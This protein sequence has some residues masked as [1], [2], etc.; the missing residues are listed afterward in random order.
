MRRHSAPNTV[1]LTTTQ[2]KALDLRRNIA[3]TASAGS[4][5]TR[6]LVERYLRILDERSDLGVENI[7]AITF[8]NKAAA[9]MRER[10]RRAVQE[11][12]DERPDEQERWVAVRDSLPAA[13]ISTIHAFCSS[14]LRQHPI[15]AGVDP[16]F[17]MLEDADRGVLIED[18]ADSALLRLSQLDEHDPKRAALWAGLRMWGRHRLSSLLRNL[19]SRR[20]AVAP[21]FE[22]IRGKAQDEIVAWMEEMIEEHRRASIA[23]LK[24]DENL[25]AFVEQLRASGPGGERDADASIKLND[26]RIDV[27]ASWDA[28]CRAG[29]PSSQLAALEEI[30]GINVRGGS[31]KVWPEAALDACKEALKAIRDGAKSGLKGLPELG[32][33]DRE[34]AGLLAALCVLVD[35]A[36]AEYW[37]H[38]GAGARL[39][40][41]DLEEIACRMLAEN[42]GGARD[43]YRGQFAYVLVDEFQDTNYQQWAIVSEIVGDAPDRLFVVGDPKQSIY[44]FRGAVIDVF[45]RVKRDAVVTRNTAAGLADAPFFDPHGKELPAEEHEKLGDV[46]MAESF[47]S[48]QAIADFVNHLFERVMAGGE[49]DWDPPYEPLIARREERAPGAVELLIAEPSGEAADGDDEY[50]ATPDD[51]ARLLAHRLCALVS[52][53][54]FNVCDPDTEELRPAKFDDVV[55]LLRGRSRLEY[56][57][58]AL[59][60]QHIPFDVVAGVGFYERQEVRDI[61]NVLRVLSNSDNDIALVGVLRSPLFGLSD[62]AIFRISLAPGDRMLDKLQA[63]VESQERLD[64]L[65]DDAPLAEFADETLRRWA[66]VGPRLP[67]SELIRRIV[68]ETGFWA[69]LSAGP[70]GDQDRANIEK[71]IL[72]AQQFQRRGLVS[73]AD[74]AERIDALMDRGQQEG[75]A[76]VAAAG[77]GIRI[78]TVHAA[79]GLEAPIV[80]VADTA[81]QFN[82]SSSDP[83]YFDRDWGFGIKAPNPDEGYPIES[84]ALRQIINKVQRAKTVAEEKR[85]F[86]VACTRARDM[87]I[88]SSRWVK[89]PRDS[90]AAW[91]HQAFGLAAGEPCVAFMQDGRDCEA[92]VHCSADAFAMSE[93]AAA[94][95]PFYAAAE[96]PAASPAAYAALER[97]V[98]PLPDTDSM[99]RFSPT[100]LMLFAQCPTLHYLAYELGVAEE[101]VALEDRDAALPTNAARAQAIARGL[102]A[103]RLFERLEP[104]DGSHDAALARAV[105]NESEGVGGEE[106]EQLAQ[107]LAAMA[108]QFRASEIGQQALGAA[109]HRN[110]ASFSLRVAGGLLEGQIDKLYLGP[111]GQWVVL[112]YKTNSI[113]PREKEDTAHKYD[114]QLEAYALAASRLL[115]EAPPRLRAVLYFTAINDTAWREFNA[116]ELAGIEGRI[117][118]LI[119]RVAAFDAGEPPAMRPACHACGYRESGVCRP[120]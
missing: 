7:L 111:D 29:D 65:G 44:S 101:T 69:V 41:T 59:R 60:D 21:C 12:I 77:R 53:G 15:E 23:A 28:F 33:A 32:P 57:E 112:D 30:A 87:L 73:L 107:E 48:R 71:L 38:K 46:A 117:S 3:V 50:R 42:V 36:V 63:T 68:E 98:Q 118:D 116:D 58:D 91:V 104:G 62:E 14:L 45:N 49:Q 100:E 17:E 110:E 34:A 90:W 113:Q 86:Y 54:D 55:I 43:Q 99:R 20:D 94:A 106:R 96:P 1:P 40:Y 25:A 37:R 105:L 70:R 78:M 120:Q 35:E 79:K 109:D 72:T 84:T 2:Q 119:T 39:D 47:R 83:I 31:K 51:E 92:P 52:A 64:A 88:L 26:V 5:K 75:E 19:I 16:A 74:L 97:S 80:V 4:G 56:F 95:P 22:R 8:T 13:H 81:T 61:T 93:P 9:E 82:F 10:V 11:R 24:S 66:G 76:A 89:K 6:V 114:L 103:H 85:L 27:L 18:A 67:A 115:A 102:A 108:K